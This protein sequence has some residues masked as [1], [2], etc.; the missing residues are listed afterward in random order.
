[1]HIKSLAICIALSLLSLSSHALTLTKG[2]Q[3]G[4]CRDLLPYLQD[5]E[6]NGENGLAS[7]PIFTPDGKVFK[8][9]KWQ[10]IEKYDGLK[11]NMQKLSLSYMSFKKWRQHLD[12]TE[13][14]VNDPN[15]HYQVEISNI[16]I[17]NNGTKEKILRSSFY[18]KDAI[19]W[20]YSQD[21]VTNNN[22]LD[23]GFYYTDG[24]YPSIPGEVFFY[25]GRTFSISLS[26]Y[27]NSVNEFFDS[28]YGDS[29]IAVRSE[30][31]LFE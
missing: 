12:R 16:D 18:S 27:K 21:V 20:F 23:I 24:F 13:K 8:A 30:L 2:E 1:M 11:V 25:E 14:R 28:P 5:I 17:N 6:A 9:P 22:N 29:G 7:R 3:Y 31:C 10:E 26:K 19:G 15:A 4:V